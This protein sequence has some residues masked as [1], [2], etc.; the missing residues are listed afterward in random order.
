MTT[1]AQ[2]GAWQKCADSQPEQ[3]G[4]NLV[5]VPTRWK[6]RMVTMGYYHRPKDYWELDG[7]SQAEA[8]DDPTHWQPLPEL[9]EEAGTP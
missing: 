1:T 6:D 7:D 4:W 8:A 5:V 3:A 2:A 9:P